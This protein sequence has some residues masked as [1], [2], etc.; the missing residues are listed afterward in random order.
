MIYTIYT[1]VKRDNNRLNKV[2][3]VY[4]DSHQ[5]NHLISTN[6]FNNYNNYE[7]DHISETSNSNHS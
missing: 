3:E 7:E 1:I 6:T 4:N 2:D 5:R